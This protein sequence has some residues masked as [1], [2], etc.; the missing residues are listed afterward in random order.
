M[1]PVK[2]YTEHHSI[3]R[4]N[5]NNYETI[6]NDVS[7]EE[8]ERNHVQTSQWT[9]DVRICV[10]GGLDPMK[11]FSTAVVPRICG[12]EGAPSV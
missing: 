9:K 7:R 4:S 6:G 10:L 3:S 12:V 11:A 1:L 5:N 2:R 8:R